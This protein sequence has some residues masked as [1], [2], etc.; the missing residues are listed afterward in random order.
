M[1][2]IEYDTYTNLDL[3]E[4]RTER[5]RLEGQENERASLSW[6]LTSREKRNIEENINRIEN[7]EAL[8]RIWQLLK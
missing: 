7:R 6:H 2:A 8:N 1:V 4:Y 5:Q 3:K